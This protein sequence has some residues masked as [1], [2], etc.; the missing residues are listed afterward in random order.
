MQVGAGLGVWSPGLS[1][2]SKGQTTRLWLLESSSSKIPALIAFGYSKR[3]ERSERVSAHDILIGVYQPDTSFGDW[4]DRPYH[5]VQSS[6]SQLVTRVH[7]SARLDEDLDVHGAAILCCKY[8]A[9][10]S[11]G[12]S[13]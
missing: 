7:I 4:F 13:S 1:L 2:V 10:N 11:M 9:G 5:P 6:V 12:Q 8:P 3:M